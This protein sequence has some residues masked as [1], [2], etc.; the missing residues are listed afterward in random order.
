ML[1]EDAVKKCGS[2]SETHQ[3]TTSCMRDSSSLA[4]SKVERRTHRM[5]CNIGYQKPDGVF[6]LFSLVLPVVSRIACITSLHFRIAPIYPK[7][8]SNIKVLQRLS[9]PLNSA[10]D[11]SSKKKQTTHNTYNTYKTIAL[12][13][14][15]HTC[16][17][18]QNTCTRCG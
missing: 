12:P 15:F 1:Q 3:R 18:G 17:T 2:S 7:V 5:T 10:L 16:V 8:A 13:L 9:T 6:L 14:R 11:N 4:R